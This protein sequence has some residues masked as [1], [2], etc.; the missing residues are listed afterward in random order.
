MD[1]L[2]YFMSPLP[3]D[4]HSEK[5]KKPTTTNLHFGGLISQL[6]GIR[7]SRRKKV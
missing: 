6:L 4:F 5:K 7:F 1:G 3:P 2:M